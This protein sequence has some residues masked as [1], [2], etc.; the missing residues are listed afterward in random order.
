MKLNNR[1]SYV[2]TERG[3]PVGGVSLVE[4]ENGE[5]DD[6]RILRGRNPGR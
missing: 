1:A 3:C 2:M 5:N 4:R 6:L